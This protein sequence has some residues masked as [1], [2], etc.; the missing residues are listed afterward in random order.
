MT[1]PYTPNPASVVSRVIDYFARN[2]DEEL[3]SADVALKFQI[4]PGSV[5]PTLAAAV[6]AGL[7]TQDISQTDVRGL[8]RKGQA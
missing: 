5:G 2:P 1:R 8:Y 6:R 3:T 7:L 4:L